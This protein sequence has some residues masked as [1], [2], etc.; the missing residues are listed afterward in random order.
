MT[1]LKE[2][3]PH[4]HTPKIRLENGHLIAT[5]MIECIGLPDRYLAGRT[6]YYFPFRNPKRG[7][8]LIEP[9]FD[10][11]YHT[12]VQ[13]KKANGE[14]W[15]EDLQD[16]D[17][18]VGYEA[19]LKYTAQTYQTVELGLT[20][21]QTEHGIPFA[22][23]CKGEIQA[24]LDES[25]LYSEAYNAS[26]ELFNVMKHHREEVSK[27][28]QEACRY[29]QRLAALTAEVQSEIEIRLNKR[30]QGLEEFVQ[31]ETDFKHC[32]G[33]PRLVSLGQSVMRSEPE[34]LTPGYWRADPLEVDLEEVVK[35]MLDSR[36]KKN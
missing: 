32:K 3:T 22:E 4:I 36:K 31:D 10:L 34:K 29:L 26:I 23:L 28:A 27:E 5:F 17:S 30:A 25:K 21:F 1:F 16:P 35:I 24:A 2:W 11:Y 7:G 13:L 19:Q 14:S 9:H 18:T 12:P 8:K 20:Q 6:C 33:N 15:L